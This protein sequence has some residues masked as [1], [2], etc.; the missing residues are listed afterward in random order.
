MGGFGAV[1]RND[2]GNFATATCGCFE[3]VCSPLQAEALAFQETLHWAVNK[4]FSN[5]SFESDSLQIVE[6]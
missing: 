3:G 6:A 2:S 1:V 4:G 5:L